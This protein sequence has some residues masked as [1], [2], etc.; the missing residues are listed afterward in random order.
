MGVAYKPALSNAYRHTVVHSSSQLSSKAMPTYFE[1]ASLE[2]FPFGF[3]SL[4]LDVFYQ[5][6]CSQSVKTVS[7]V[8]KFSLRYFLQTVEIREIHKI[9][10]SQ[11]FCAIQYFSVK[12]SLLRST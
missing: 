7:H 11:K 8:K 2:R 5:Q 10:D 6:S 3:G 1:D 9:K 12:C 4:P